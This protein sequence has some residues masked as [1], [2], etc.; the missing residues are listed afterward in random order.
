MKKRSKIAAGAGAALAVAGAGAAVAA[1]RQ[2]PKAES[3]AI[4]LLSGHS[5]PT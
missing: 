1:D 2:T 3:Q 4:V 5:D